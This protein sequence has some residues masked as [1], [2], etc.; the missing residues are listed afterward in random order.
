MT[1][2]LPNFYRHFRVDSSPGPGALAPSIVRDLHQL[3]TSGMRYGTIYA[4]PPWQYSNTAARGAAENYYRTMS[5]RELCLEPVSWLL[6]E[7][8]YLHVCTTDSC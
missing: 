7:N 3:A 5:L 1:E 2:S 8:A 6:A 4:A